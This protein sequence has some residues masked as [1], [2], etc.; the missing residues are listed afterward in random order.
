MAR[1]SA[2]RCRRDA[3]A[4]V[5]GP[6]GRE[7]RHPAWRQVKRIRKGKGHEVPMKRNVL[8]SLPLVLTGA[9]VFA[10][11]ALPPGASPQSPQDPGYQALIATCKTP[12][13]PP[14]ARGG[15]PGRAGGGA[16]AAAAPATFPPAPA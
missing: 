1:A 5:A 8:L 3:A 7:R 13:P 15:G 14:A 16:A 10:Q 4:A 6:R 2:Q 11:V 9:V 12:P